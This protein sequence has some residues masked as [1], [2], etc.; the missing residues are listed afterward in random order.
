MSQIGY[1]GVVVPDK[2]FW[3]GF[4]IDDNAQAEA[5]AAIER[6]RAHPMLS[7]AGK[8]FGR[9]DVSHANQAIV[10][11]CCATLVEAALAE[12]GHMS[13]V[14]VKKANTILATYGY[15]LC[16]IIDRPYFWIE[17]RSAEGGVYTTIQPIHVSTISQAR[18]YINNMP[19]VREIKRRLMRKLPTTPPHREGQHRMSTMRSAGQKPKRFAAVDEMIAEINAQIPRKR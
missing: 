1:F 19:A 2:D 7:N 6:M 3:Q 16:R 18:T 13:E 12:T 17:G 9:A 15:A 10:G 4:F 11:T 5:M 14:P 8:L